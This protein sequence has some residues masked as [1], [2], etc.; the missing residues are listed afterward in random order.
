LLSELPITP[1]M[2]STNTAIAIEAG[3]P[4]SVTAPATTTA[5]YI[6]SFEIFTPF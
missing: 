2:L 5:N 3:S 6:T 4:I 1:K